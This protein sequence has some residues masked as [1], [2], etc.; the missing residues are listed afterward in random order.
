MSVFD[1]DNKFGFNN[2]FKHDSVRETHTIKIN[3]NSIHEDK[4]PSNFHNSIH[5]HSRIHESMHLGNHN[6]ISPFNHG[7]KQK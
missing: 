6:T 3:H 2:S 4:H 7:N 5:D 1:D